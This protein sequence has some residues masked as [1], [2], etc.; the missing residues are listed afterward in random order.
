MAGFSENFGSLSG[1][2]AL[3]NH[4]GALTIGANNL[5]ATYS[6]VIGG[7]LGT[8]STA[9]NTGTGSVSKVGLGTQTFSGVNLYTGPTNILGGTLL[10]GSGTATT[11]SASLANTLVTVGSNGQT[12]TLGGNGTIAGQVIVNPTGQLA[13]AMSPLTANTLTIN[14]NLT[15][16]AGA[17][18]NYNFAAAGA[19]GTG[20]QVNLTGA[21]NLV[22]NAGTDVLNITS[23]AGF[24]LGTYNLISVNGT[25][26][27]TDNATFT[28]NGSSL[29]NYAVAPSGK[30]LVL[31]VTPGS[32]N[33]VWTGVA[34]GSPNG[35]WDVGNTPNWAGRARRSPTVET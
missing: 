10:I 14:N 2:L 6:G 28:I 27:F 8:S 24:G 18:L 16:N 26:T 3:I 13:P 12:G 34:N 29:Y 25:G 20:D 22:L 21:G 7:S 31:T 33:F 4:T 30:T 9:I 23:L 35:T 19:P 11:S 32:P 15:I 5:S 1:N 17:T